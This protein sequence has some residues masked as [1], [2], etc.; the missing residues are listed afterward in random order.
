MPDRRRPRHVLPSARRRD[1]RASIRTT[2]HTDRVL[3]TWRVTTETTET[4]ELLVSELVTNAVK[5]SGTA[6]AR[7]RY[8][9]PA[10]VLNIALT[11]GYEAGRLIID[12]FDW[13]TVTPL[14]LNPRPTAQGGR[15]LLLVQAMSTELSCFCPLSGGKVVRCVIDE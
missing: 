7:V 4:A 2:P 9:S 10:G 11:L 15:G 14:P 8:A 6:P 13:D 1:D 5:F 3:D 12:V